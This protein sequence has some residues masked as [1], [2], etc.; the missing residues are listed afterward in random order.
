[1]CNL[2]IM[3]PQNRNFLPIL[4]F[5]VI[6]VKHLGVDGCWCALWSSK[7]VIAVSS[8]IGGFNSHT[9]PPKAHS[10]W[11]GLFLFKIS[12]IKKEEPKIGSSF[13][14]S[15]Q[16]AWSVVWFKFAGEEHL[17]HNLRTIHHAAAAGA[18]AVGL[19]VGSA[20]VRTNHAGVLLL[21]AFCHLF[22]QVKGCK[23]GCR[24]C[25]VGIGIFQSCQHHH[26]A[27]AAA[28]LEHSCNA[29]SIRPPLRER[30]SFHPFPTA[31][32]RCRRLPDSSYIRPCVSVLLPKLYFFPFFSFLSCF[33]FINKLPQTDTKVPA[34]P[35]LPL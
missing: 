15:L 22:A 20:Q 19:A 32:S 7:P 2:P 1:M 21:K 28:G 10:N 18:Q 5:C 29:Q 23:F 8:C 27:Y 12:A 35:H 34:L 24:L 30:R 3:P 26:T 4:F 31:R 25:E 11:N 33:P 13:L 6:L 16:L 9:F 17:F 14:H